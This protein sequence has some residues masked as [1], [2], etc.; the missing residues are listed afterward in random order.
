V[1]FRPDIILHKISGQKKDEVIAL[2]VFNY[3]ATKMYVGMEVLL[4]AFLIFVIFGGC[5]S[6]QHSGGGDSSRLM[7]KTAKPA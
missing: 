7:Y 6:D 3:Q 4:H 2:V 1:V 5:W